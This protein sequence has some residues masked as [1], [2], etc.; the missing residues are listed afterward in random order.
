MAKTNASFPCFPNDNTFGPT[1]P[2][3]NSTDPDYVARGGFDFTLFFEQSILGI[4]PSAVLLLLVPARIWFLKSRGRRVRRGRR[5]VAKLIAIALYGVLQL[6]SLILWARPAAH[7]T[8]ASVAA[9]TLGLIDAVALC[10]LSYTEHVKSIQ[11]SS[12]ISLFVLFTVIFDAV[13]CRTLWLL[14]G[15][16]ALAVLISLGIAVKISMLVLEGADKRRL[17]MPRWIGSPPEAISGI[18]NRGIFWWV[19]EMM[20][21]GWRGLLNVNRLYPTDSALRSEKLLER[22]RNIWD[23]CRQERRHALAFALVKSLKWP[24]F[25]GIPPRLCHICFTFAQPFL[26]NAIIDYL[27]QPHSKSSSNVDYG[28]IGATGLVYVGLAVSLIKP[29][30]PVLADFDY[31]SDIQCYIQSKGK[32]IC[33]GMSRSVS[34]IDIFKD[35]RDLSNNCGNQRFRNINTYEYRC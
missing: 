30:G 22:L 32:Q 25:A 15:S 19:N 5:G 4:G 9:A 35:F 23:K 10:V 12:I 17:L 7:K 14:P 24:L 8:D 20:G 2:A 16:K 33:N 18:L 27:G 29:P 3:C 11:P 21:Q 6:L 34:L 28:L 13:Q 1:I 26:I 31:L